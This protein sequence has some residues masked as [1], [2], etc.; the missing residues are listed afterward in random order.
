MGCH[1]DGSARCLIYTT[2]FHTNNTVF[3]DIYDTDTM[4]TSKSVQ[5]CDDLRNFHGFSV[6]CFRNPLFKSH[7][8][9]FPF[10]RSLFRCHAKHQHVFEVW[11]VCRIFQLQTFVADVP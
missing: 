9:I 11:L 7:G 1:Q 4:F 6:Q 8:N 5:L 10:F 2:G 3:Y